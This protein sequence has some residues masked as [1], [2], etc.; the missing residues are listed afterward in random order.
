MRTFQQLLLAS[1]FILPSVINVQSAYAEGAPLKP[2]V[3]AP[4]P[5]MLSAEPITSLPIVISETDLPPPV[6]MTQITSKNLY[7]VELA[8]DSQR[9][10]AVLSDPELNALSA[11][12]I[13]QLLLR[14][15]GKKALLASPRA[16]ILLANP[17]NL[18]KTY[19]YVPIVQEGVQVGRKLRLT[20]D[21]IAVK[22]AL[23]QAQIKIWPLN[24]RPKLL[25]MGTLVE[26]N[27]VTKLN[28]E[29]LQYR[30]DV[31]LLEQFAQLA[32]PAMVPVDATTWVYP[33][34]PANNIGPLQDVMVQT[35]Q[36][37]L[38]SYKLNHRVD[39]FELSWYLFAQ[40][41]TVLA[42]GKANSTERNVLFNDMVNL[43]L[44]RLVE[45]NRDLLE[46]NDQVV[47]NLTNIRDLQAIGQATQQLEQTIPTL[48]DLR[49]VTVEQQLAQLQIAFRGD[50]ANLMA[51]LASLPQFEILRSSEMLRQVDAKFTY[52]EPPSRGE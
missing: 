43:V 32:L 49:L 51:W 45:L 29:A 21:E 23:A 20:F 47:I 25:L 40:N 16:A 41:G 26:N 11:Q 33:M 19:D 46:V 52:I 35:S 3:V 2:A 22:S 4:N 7:Q 50:Y 48:T 18:L 30:V 27:S 9:G 12:A 42:K 5:P 44:A 15:T 6:Q 24:L 36:D 17:R 14:L 38:L 13:R 28:K 34:N 31:N 1:V 37:K 8:H 10:N 39:D